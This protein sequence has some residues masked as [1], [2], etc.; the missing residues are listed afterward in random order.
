MIDAT[1][2]TGEFTVTQ[3]EPKKINV[4][5]HANCV[6]GFAS[7]Y[8]VW[9]TYGDEAAYHPCHYGEPCPEFRGTDV[10]IV[11]FSFNRSILNAI[12]RNNKSVLVLDHHKTAMAELM[13]EDEG[14]H[15][16]AHPELD[17][18]I[19]VQFDMTKSGALLTWEYFNM[20]ADAPYWVKLISMRDLWNHKRPEHL[21][22]WENACEAFNA[23]VNSYAFDFKIWDS[24]LGTYGSV[25]NFN[26]HAL[27]NEGIAI[28]RFRKVT[29]ENICKGAR[30]YNT[31]HGS[32]PI[33]NANG[34]FASEVGDI[35]N[36]SGVPHSISWFA[37]A[38][39]NAI[40]S[41]RSDS[42]SWHASDVSVIA[43]QYGGGGHKNAAGCKMP[44]S[45]FFNRFLG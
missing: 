1:S 40:L 42:A 18:N 5:Y 36:K 35:L 19:T 9:K 7:A 15:M 23:A 6:D 13:Q 16:Q 4:L 21:E 34:M 14:G 17:D 33:V 3:G 29:V 45:E 22:E 20:D 2:E 28:Q 37:D 10:V 38:H 12:A 27:I 32:V 26:T 11:D 39:G 30:V 24:W 31:R 44:L 8:I 41:F 25:L 43:K